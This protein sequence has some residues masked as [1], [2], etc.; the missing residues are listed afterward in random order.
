MTKVYKDFILLTIRFYLI[1]IVVSI[2]FPTF[3]V[4]FETELP[5]TM[6]FHPL[7]FLEQML[8]FSLVIT[9]LF[10]FLTRVSSLAILSTILFG[11]YNSQFGMNISDLEQPAVWVMLL[12][13]MMVDGAGRLSLDHEFT[14]IFRSKK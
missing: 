7:T 8:P 4:N 1:Y 2:L 3:G 6:Q 14:T 12:G 9:M 10:G 11:L 5:N 13:I